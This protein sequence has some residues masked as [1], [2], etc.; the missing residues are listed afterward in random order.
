M[1]EKELELHWEEEFE[2]LR[3]EEPKEGKPSRLRA[4]LLILAAVFLISIFIFYFVTDPTLRNILSGLIDSSTISKSHE[5]SIGN[6]K[7]LFF[8]NGTY[9]QLIGIYDR[10]P[11][12]EFKVCLKGEVLNGDYRIFEVYEPTMVFQSHSKVISE[13]C[14]PDTLVDMHSHPFRHCLP[15]EQDIRS[16]EEFRKSNPDA[17]MAVM[18]ERGRFSFHR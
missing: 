6:G 1:D 9:D 5:A 4:V 11:E 14:P 3:K 12:L 7:S 2:K 8:L 10:N 17:L 15:S 16:F 13:P 18:C